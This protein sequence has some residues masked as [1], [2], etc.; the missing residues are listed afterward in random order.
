MLRYPEPLN[1][2]LGV[3]D[4]I[5][6]LVILG[7]VAELVT[8]NPRRSLAAAE[9]V[10]R[11]IGHRMGGDREVV[12]VPGNHDFPLIRTWVRAR[13]RELS[14]SDPVDPSATRALSQVVSWL[15]PAAV[16]VAYPGVWLDDGVYAIHG[17]Y[18]DDH[19]FPDSAVG[20]P[21]GRLRGPVRSAT[22]WD[23]E[24]R[25]IHSRRSRDSFLTRAVR[26]PVQTAMPA[27]PRVLLRLH[28]ASV[29]AAMLDLQMRRA[30]IPAL[31]HVLR[32]F[33]L[34]ADWV[35]FG[36]VH[37]L[38]PLPSDRVEQWRDAEA[39]TRLV[40]TGAWLDEPL[41]N[42]GVSPPHPYWPGGAVLLEPG[43]DPRAVGLLDGLAPETFRRD[44]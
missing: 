28:L 3:L 9:P 29:S 16:R 37:R 34:S 43:M 36:H 1:A 12:L 7:D 19:L 35:V 22:P 33:G 42:D 20:V 26:R 41:L 8:R 21:R 38:G 2:L 31:A 4:S 39:G 44:G 10:L 30:S 17:H 27:F 18:L 14:T 5:D 13:G 25:R 6:R 23:Y 24:R 32:G 40:N 11:A 15:A